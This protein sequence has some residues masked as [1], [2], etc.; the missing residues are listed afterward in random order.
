ML[1]MIH[2]NAGRDKNTPPRFNDGE[3]IIDWLLEKHS[4]IGCTASSWFRAK[5]I[6][7][8]NIL[9]DD[10]SVLRL[11]TTFLLNSWC[12]HLIQIQVRIANQQ[13]ME[14][15]FPLMS[16]PQSNLFIHILKTNQ[17]Y[18][19]F[20]MNIITII[21]SENW[22]CVLVSASTLHCCTRVC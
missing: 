16:L 5:N 17:K 19:R 9:G 15:C 1:D 4:F 7:D 2:R 21:K 3:N 10:K 11:L 12:N 20:L 22:C 6:S 14:Q 8:A 18:C 13:S